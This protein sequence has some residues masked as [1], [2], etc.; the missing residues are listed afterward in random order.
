MLNQGTKAFCFDLILSN[1]QVTRMR[2]CLA[3]LVLCLE[4]WRCWVVRGRWRSRCRDVTF[5]LCCAGQRWLRDFLL[6]SY[7]WT[8]KRA[9]SL[10]DLFLFETKEYKLLT[11]A[12]SLF[13]S[14]RFFALNI[15]IVTN[16]TAKKW[17]T[18]G[19]TVGAFYV[20]QN[21]IAP[22]WWRSWL[23]RQ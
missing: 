10:H 4:K 12:L 20:N 2:T 21:F 3:P 19:S 7:C 5:L 18:S 16:C 14:P 22:D 8:V 11:T 13:L 6:V 1:P 9:W 23:W 15:I 17:R